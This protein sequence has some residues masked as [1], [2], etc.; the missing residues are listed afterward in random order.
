MSE[1]DKTEEAE[2]TVAGGDRLG[3]GAEAAPGPAS[4][5]RSA[6]VVSE[7]VVNMTILLIAAVILIAVFV[8]FTYSSYSSIDPEEAVRLA[9]YILIPYILLFGLTV[10]V[11]GWRLILKVIVRP[12]RE[13]LEATHKVADGDFSYRVN[14]DEDN[15]FG[16]LAAAF[17][18]MTERLDKN[19]WELM[20]NLEEMKRLNENLA[21]TQRE[22]LSSEKLAS[23]GRLAAGV[24]HE[25]GNPLAAIRGYLDI[26]SRRDYVEDKDREMIE[27]IHSEVAR[28]N[29]IIKELLDYSRPPDETL[30][31][32]D[33]NEAVASTL[34]LMRAQKGFEKIELNTDFG[35]LPPLNANRSSMQQLIMNLVVNAIHAMPD[36]GRLAIATRPAELS[37]RAGMEL[38]VEDEGMGIAQEDMDRIFDP[39]F[40]TKEPGAGTGLGLSICLKIVENIKGKISARSEP[41]KGAVFTVWLP[42]AEGTEDGM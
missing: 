33:L 41:G 29:E 11:Y 12:L 2:E 37:G 36:G 4:R 10:A 42:A 3:N 18:E 25:I 15:E 8:S 24:A 1:A 23:V 9:P 14:I 5:T 34:T 17:N 21:M 6:S 16:G 31:H 38:R 39:F 19:R 40:T 27:R 7:I 30:A 28:I 26:I 35:D 13:M 20:S 32:I 22:L